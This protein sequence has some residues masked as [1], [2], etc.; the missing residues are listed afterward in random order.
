MEK[1]INDKIRELTELNEALISS[2]KE[3]AIMTELANKDAL[4]GVNSKIAYNNEA[5]KINDSISKGNV[6]PF[7]IVMVDLNYLKLIN[8]EHGHNAGD[9]ALM[10]LCQIICDTFTHS[11]VYR[12]GGD[13]FVVIIRKNDY[14]NIDKLIN[15][16]NDKI[17]ENRHTLSAAIGYALFDPKQD[18][19]VSDVF[20]KADEAM[21]V[22]KHQMKEEDGNL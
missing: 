10:D 22:R 11:P 21:Y 5:I 16:F 8:D 3:T 1:D 4:T 14:I 2:Q 19:K 12:V 13:E 6:E 15:Q 17:E 18:G 20:K 9:K 7:G